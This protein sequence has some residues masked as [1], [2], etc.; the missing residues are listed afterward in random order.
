MPTFGKLPPQAL[1]FEESL[2]GSLLLVKGS[3]TYVV[4]VIKPDSFYKDSH[5][6]IYQALL[7]LFTKSQPTDSVSVAQ[8]LRTMGELEIA[9][10][11][12]YLIELSEKANSSYSIEHYAQI[13]EQKFMQREMIR[14]ATESISAAYEDTTDVFDLIEAHQSEVFKIGAANYSKGI[15]KIDEVIARRLKEYETKP[16]DGLTGIGSGFKSIDRIT[17]GWQ[18]SDL[19]IIAARPA[20]GKTAFVIQTAKLAALRYGTKVG[21]FSLE[22]SEDQLADRLISSETGIYQDRIQRKDLSEDDFKILHSKLQGL[23]SSGIY[24]DDS[25]GMRIMELKAKARRLKEQHGIGLIVVDYL[26]LLKGTKDAKGNREQ[27]ISEISRELKIIAKDLNIPVIALSQL[28]R[29][30]ENRPGDKR[31][32]LSDLRESGSIE[33]DADKVIFLY[34]PEYYGYSED[35]NGRSTAGICE[36]IFAKNRNGICGTAVL[37]FNGALMKFL[38]LEDVN[39]DIPNGFV[40]MQSVRNWNEPEKEDVF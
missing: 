6:K 33:Q 35:E 38:D 27:E 30:V 26:Q 7:N 18:N 1:E 34:R 11:S 5:Q 40:K 9:G 21:V 32:M 8:E 12:Y 25:P 28:S 3:M 22:M 29:A 14:V 4:G 15:S 23:I 39:V 2:L 20:M 31:P 19:I 36:A 16:I 10:G 17:S 13:I 24:I 37:N